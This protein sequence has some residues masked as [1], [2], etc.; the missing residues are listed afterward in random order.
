MSTKSDVSL[1]SGEVTEPLAGW[2]PGDEQ[3]LRDLVPRIYDQLRA[4]AD[5]LARKKPFSKTVQ[6][7]MLVNEF[8]M[9]L[10]ERT[11][12]GPLHFPT[13]LHFYAFAGTVMRRILVD[14]M[15]R[16]SAW[17]AGGR[18]MHVA[19]EEEV[20]VPADQ[21]D[22]TTL[23]ALQRALEKLAEQDPRQAR[24]VEHKYFSGL[25]VI[26]ISRLLGLSRA[27]INRELQ[28][29]RALLARELLGEPR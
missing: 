8:Y 10:A 28:T 11:A 1:A 19:L 27:T 20:S 25:T 24:I 29:A 6:P 23:L 18:A 12:A 5:R 17:R 21:P 4:I 13:R 2:T 22:Q 9:R 7:T 3:A 16:S 26:E 15:R 14:E